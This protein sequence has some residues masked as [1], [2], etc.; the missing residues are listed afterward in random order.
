MDTV[1]VDLADVKVGLHFWYVRGGDVVC[2]APDA[3]RWG[4][5]GDNCEVV[6]AGD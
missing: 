6:G 1:A 4:R 3:E 5:R 2:S